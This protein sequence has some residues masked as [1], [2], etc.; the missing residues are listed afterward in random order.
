M[1]VL[2]VTKIFPNQA[3]PLSSP[4]NRRQFAALSRLCDVEVLATIPWFPAAGA[5]RRWSSV[6]TL[7]NVP[8]SESIDGLRVKHPRYVFLPKIGHGVA[9]PL[10]AASL[11]PAALSYAGRIDVVLGSWA[12]PDGFAAVV[13]AQTLGVPAVIKLHGSD[14]NVVAKWSGPRRCLKWALPRAERVVAV[15]GALVEAAAALGVPRERIDLVPNGIDRNKFKPRDRAE[16][17]RELGLPLAGPILLYIGHVT[18]AKG[19]FDLVRAYAAAEPR[20]PNA[21]LILVGDGAEL[22][23]C[24]KL[25]Q[26]LSDTISFVGAQS[27]DRIPTWL[28]AC[29]ALALPSWNEGM[30]NVVLEAL[31]SGRRVV[32]TRVGGIPEVLS[33]ELGILVPPRDLGALEGALE[34]ILTESY[35]PSAISAQLDRPDWDGSARLLHQSLLSALQ[36]RA[37]RE[38]A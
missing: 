17:R 10:Y 29:D 21:R 5:F 9:G 25:G 28:A 14:M 1:R 31:A 4:F 11:A 7:S 32:A 3:E 30:P 24:K 35:E 15:S 19:A 13:L 12:Y 37:T 33:A 27:H 38:A 34:T 8:E 16:A 26:E 36:S 23:S 6:A 22:E 20:L 18:Q 2:I